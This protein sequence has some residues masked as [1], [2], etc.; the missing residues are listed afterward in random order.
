MKKSALFLLALPLAICAC[1]NEGKDSVE[2]ADSANQAKHED[3]LRNN[4]AT[5]EATSDFL[6]RAADGGM[7]EVQLGELAQQK[8][9]NAAVK[10]FGA[11][12]VQ[13]HTA[14]NNQVKALAAGRN[15]TLPASVSDEHKKK[16]DDLSK[17]SGKD[18]DKAFMS[19]MVSDHEKT[20]DLFKS[21]AEKS[22][23][24]DVKT[25]ANN[26]LPKLQHHLDSARAIQKA[27][28]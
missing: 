18:F 16:A 1:N 15:V 27:V 12:M 2:K 4:I 25:F 9:T 6:V 19:A 24:P 5:D 17:K 23:D 26:T 8:A 7:A 28:K 20:I 22:N 14:A 10:E 3:T 13:D 11:M 21:G